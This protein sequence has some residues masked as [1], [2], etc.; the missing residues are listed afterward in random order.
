MDC[1]LTVGLKSSLDTGNGRA[2]P[3]A[4]NRGD[5]S[6]SDEPLTFK[7][8][9]HY[10]STYIDKCTTVTLRTKSLGKPWETLSNVGCTW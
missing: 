8:K 9:E 3:N 6:Q 5:S 4:K 10:I 7:S 1:G 2:D